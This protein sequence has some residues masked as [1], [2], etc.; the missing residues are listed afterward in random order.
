DLRDQT[1]LLRAMRVDGLTEENK[2]KCEAGEHVFAEIGHD[3]HGGQAGTHLGESERGVVRDEREVAHDCEAEAEP[4]SVSLHLRDT[5]K[6]R[7]PQGDFELDQ[8][9]RFTTD[10]RQGA[11]RALT[12]RAENIAARSNA[13][14]PGA[15]LCCF[16]AEFDQH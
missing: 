8:A 2:G 5:N 16:L 14:Y 7:G 10:C 1:N 15:R 11:A 13:Q 9:R 12:P 4:E 6:W 3:G